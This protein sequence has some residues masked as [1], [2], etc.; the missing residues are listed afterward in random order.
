MQIKKN[1]IMATVLY[2]LKQWHKQRFGKLW[3]YCQR[4]IDTQ[5]PL[6][7]TLPNFQKIIFQEHLNFF[8]LYHENAFI[9]TGFFC[10]FIFMIG[11]KKPGFLSWSHTQQ[12]KNHGTL[13]PALC[14]P[15]IKLRDTL[16]KVLAGTAELALFLPSL[17]GL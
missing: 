9:K 3:Q 14:V 16:I 13:V 7:Y 15:A 12:I 5:E 17:T 2:M 6:S 4:I 8:V 10:F 11:V 1:N